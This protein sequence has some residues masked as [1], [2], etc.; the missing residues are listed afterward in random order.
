M[1]RTTVVSRITILVAVFLCQMC[2][3]SSLRA[4]TAI[5][6]VNGT[7]TSE[8]AVQFSLRDP[9]AP[10]TFFELP[11][12]AG[13][14]SGLIADRI[15]DKID[16]A[17]GFFADHVGTMVT[18]NG[19]VGELGTAP[20]DL[21]IQWEVDTMGGALPPQPNFPLVNQPVP[22][23]NH[24]LSLFIAGPDGTAVPVQSTGG[25]PVVVRIDDNT[26]VLDINET[27]PFDSTMT[28]EDVNASL[29]GIL[30]GLSFPTGI[31]YT[32]LNNGFPTIESESPFSFSVN[33]GTIG[34]ASPGFDTG[35]VA[36]SSVPE[37]TS[38]LMA[39]F[40]TCGV[41]LAWRRKQSVRPA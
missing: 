32:G 19:K 33:M 22:G 24:S 4:A 5:V 7:A 31:S 25:L 41:A 11:V 30:A 6:T 1:S 14:S 38:A 12:S 18:V 36:L 17:P 13:N 37:P 8:G 29:D 21:R 9:G 23:M 28:T 34:N 15:E 39:V 27:V 16:T 40:A 20:S 35:F 3:T 26:S 2:T 10:A